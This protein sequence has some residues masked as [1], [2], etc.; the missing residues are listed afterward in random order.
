MKRYRDLVQEHIEKPISKKSRSLRIVEPRGGETY[1][2]FG[3][4]EE[5]RLFLVQVKRD[6]YHYFDTTYP[7]EPG[8]VTILTVRD[9]TENKYNIS[10]LTLGSFKPKFFSGYKG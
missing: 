3:S 7:K 4:F 8:D 2:T 9:K 1:L 10:K 6:S 5:L